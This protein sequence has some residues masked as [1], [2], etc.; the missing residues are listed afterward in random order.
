MP[1]NS[2]I[3]RSSSTIRMSPVSGGMVSV[4]LAGDED[5]EPAQLAGQR[6]VTDGVLRPGEQ[7]AQRGEPVH[8]GH[9]GHHPHP[10]HP[11]QLDVGRQVRPG[12]GHGVVAG[13]DVAL[14]GAGGDLARAAQALGQRSGTNTGCRTPAAGGRRGAPAGPARPAPRGW[15]ARG[16]AP[17]C[18]RPGRTTGRAGAR[19]SAIP[20]PP[21]A[22]APGPG[23]ASP[24][25][26]PAPP[27]CGPP[28]PPAAAAGRSRS[29]PRTRPARR[30]SVLISS[31]SSSS[32]SL[33]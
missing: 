24:A 19:R 18:C 22:R 27:P 23:P 30:R 33:W 25:T 15:A 5:Q 4:A 31:S 26:G 20:A 11:H 12:L 6:Q 8:R 32:I 21:A 9:R 17:S 29:R 2:R 28:R 13:E 3:E 7:P 14:V 16:P 10:A 1:R